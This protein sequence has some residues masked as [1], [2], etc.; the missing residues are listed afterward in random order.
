MAQNSNKLYTVLP[1]VKKGVADV[2]RQIHTDLNLED[3]TNEIWVDVFDYDGVYEVSNLGRF[4][5]LQREANTRWGSTRTVQEKILKQSVRKAENGRIDGLQ[6]YV[7]KTK[8]SA[9]FIFQSFFPEIDFK[10]NE[11][12]MHINKDCLDNR[13][14]NLKKVTRK[15]SKQNDMVKSI[16]TIIATPKNLQKAVETNKEFYDNRTHKECSKCGKIDLVD[17][18]PNDVSKCQN[19]INNYVV[20]KREKYKY[21]NTEK[22]CNGCGEVKKHIKFPKLDNTCKKCRYEIHKQYQIE[23]RE[24]LGDWYV[25]EYGKANYGHKIFTKDLINELR[26]EIINRDSPKYFLDNESFVTISDFARY[27]ELKYSI[28]KTTTEKRIKSG[29][30]EIDC[31]LSES[32]YRRKFSGTDKGQIKITDCVTKQ[33]YLFKNTTD[34]K[35]QDMFSLATITRKVNTGKPTR[36]TKASKYK[37]PCLIERA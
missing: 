15:K 17:S 3:F 30:K 31:T 13:I 10:K 33:I 24:N 12:V 36:V 27:V 6:V 25:K 32:D 22:K 29:A 8:N 28:Q 11:C 16:R 18:F 34:K 5:S 20:K 1:N 7:G 19:C 26:N 21:T 14:E 4:K 37:N 23:Q 9:K 35:I 2:G